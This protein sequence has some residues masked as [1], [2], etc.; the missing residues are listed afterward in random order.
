MRS[1]NFPGTLYALSPA[2]QPGEGTEYA[3]QLLHVDSGG[4]KYVAVFTDKGRA[5]ACAARNPTGTPLAPIAF[6][7]PEIFL[8]FLNGLVSTGDTHVAIDPE[9][10]SVK[11][12]AIADLAGV[13]RGS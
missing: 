5:E 8:Q 9:G 6:Q 2:S 3:S 13:I 10:V 1:P 12:I 4:S 7:T 11:L